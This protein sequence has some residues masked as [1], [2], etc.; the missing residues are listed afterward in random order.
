MM[1]QGRETIPV[2]LIHKGCQCEMSYIR[3]PDGLDLRRRLCSSLS[4][5]CSRLLGIEVRRLVD[6]DVMLSG[7]KA[8]R[9]PSEG[10]SKIRMKGDP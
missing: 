2:K 8:K 6:T 9:V 10:K 4:F 5:F 7:Y 1:C 3:P